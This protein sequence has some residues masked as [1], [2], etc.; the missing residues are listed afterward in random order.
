VGITAYREVSGIGLYLGD[1]HTSRDTK[2][3]QR[4]MEALAEA[5]AT[6]SQCA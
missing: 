5:F 3:D 1:L 6:L 4:N 2:A